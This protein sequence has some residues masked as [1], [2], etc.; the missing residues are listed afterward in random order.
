MIC[1][2]KSYFSSQSDTLGRSRWFEIYH[3]CG[4]ITE[5][6][7]L[8][9][10]CRHRADS[11]YSTLWKTRIDERGYVPCQP[12]EWL[13]L[14]RAAGEPADGTVAGESNASGFHGYLKS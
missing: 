1:S 8:N 7:V 14:P 2:R 13:G 9:V 3:G 4:T 5:A 12:C 10:E 6:A 11:A